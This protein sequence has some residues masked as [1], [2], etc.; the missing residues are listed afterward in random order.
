MWA[1][2]GRLLQR[3]AFLEELE[4]RSAEAGLSDKITTLQKSMDDLGFSPRTFDL[5]W[6]EG[7]VYVMGFRLG[8]QYWKNF[9]KPGGYMAISEITWLTQNRPEEIEAHWNAIYPEIAPA[10]AKMRILEEN[11]FSPIGYFTLPESSWMENYYLPMEKRFKSFLE[12]HPNNPLAIN[13]VKEEEE[14][15]KL[16]KI[17]ED[18]LSYGFYIA[19]KQ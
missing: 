12:K 4:R 8:V 3:P 19:K 5:I 14:E 7:A 1:W 11:G 18:F 16:Y 10:S 9:L 2:I 15:M 13:I 6:S 17:Y